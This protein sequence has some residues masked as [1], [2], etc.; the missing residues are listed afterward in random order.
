MSRSR[1]WRW[2]AV[3]AIAVM[4]TGA[5]FSAAC[6]GD[7]D[8]DSDGGTTVTAR[9][10]AGSATEAGDATEPAG[11]ATEPAG[12]STAP[13]SGGGDTIGTAENT[14]LGTIL[15]DAE[16]MTLY[17]FTNDTANSGESAC[18]DACAQAWPPLT[19]EG[20]PTA[21]DGIDG[22]LATIERTDGTTQVTYK[23]L[24]LY[25]FAS[26]ATPGDTN[27]HEVGG[28]WFVAQP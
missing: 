10:P 17:T 8:S 9:T 16:G 3:L 19:V 11:E 4:A 28:I 22:E 26:D 14:E 6:G 20:E 24:P 13:A 1:N 7:D 21:G 23:G 12:E 5:V 2:I 27:G 25:F 15:V 18:V